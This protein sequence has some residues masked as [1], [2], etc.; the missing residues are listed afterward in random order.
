VCG[1]QLVAAIR[2][3]LIEGRGGDDA[4]YS[5]AT[6]TAHDLKAGIARLHRQQ[7]QD[8]QQQQGTGI[9]PAR[10]RAATPSPGEDVL[11][12]AA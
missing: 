4:V 3:A 12:V 6:E 8:Q 9:S 1:G 7:Q 5:A 10:V 11:V 2:A